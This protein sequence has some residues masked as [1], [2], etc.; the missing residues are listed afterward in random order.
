MTSVAQAVALALPK[1]VLDSVK[2]AE[3]F[4]AFRKKWLSNEE[5]VSVLINYDAHASWLSTELQQRPASGTLLLVNRKVTKYKKDGY[6]WKMRKDSRVTREDNMR[7]KIHSYELVKCL[8]AHSSLVP[9]FHRRSYWLFVNPDVV[10]VHYLND[11]DDPWALRHL[12]SNPFESRPDFWPTSRQWNKTELMNEIVPM[13]INSCTKDAEDDQLNLPDNVSSV[14]E[15]VDKLLDDQSKFVDSPAVSTSPT[16]QKASGY[17]KAASYSNLSFQ[18]ASANSP[19]SNRSKFRPICVGVSSLSGHN[20]VPVVLNVQHIQPLLKV[21]KNETESPNSSGILNVSSSGSIN[22][23]KSPGVSYSVVSS[24]LIEKSPTDVSKRLPSKCEMGTQTVDEIVQESSTFETSSSYQQSA[25][26]YKVSTPSSLFS[27][28]TVAVETPLSQTEPPTVSASDPMQQAHCCFITSEI[29][30]SGTLRAGYF[31]ETANNGCS[32]CVHVNDLSC[33]YSSCLPSTCENNFYHPNQGSGFNESH[34]ISPDVFYHQL[35]T[36][37]NLENPSNLCK[38]ENQTYNRNSALARAF[39]LSSFHSDSFSS[40]GQV[41]SVG[42][43]SSGSCASM[44]MESNSHFQM[45]LQQQ[46]ENLN[47]CSAFSSNYQSDSSAYFPNYDLIGSNQINAS[48]QN[49]Q[50]NSLV[51]TES[52]HTDSASRELFTTMDLPDLSHMDGFTEQITQLASASSAAQ[53]KTLCH[54]GSSDQSGLI[55]GNVDGLVYITEYSPSWCYEEGGE[56][57]LIAGNWSQGNQNDLFQCHFGEKVTQG[58]LILPGVLRCVSPKSICGIVPLSVSRNNTFVT[59]SVPFEYKIKPGT[60]QGCDWF[61]MTSDSSD[62]LALNDHEFRYRL[63]SRLNEMQSH[64]MAFIGNRITH[65]SSSQEDYGNV[66]HPC[67]EAG[68]SFELK[69]ERQFSFILQLLAYLKQ[70]NT[71]HGMTELPR[72]PR[73]L[74]MLHLAAA[75]GMP[76]LIDTMRSCLTQFGGLSDLNPATLDDQHCSALSWACAR[77]NLECALIL[78]NWCHEMLCAKNRLDLTPLMIARMRGHVLLVETLADKET[79]GAPEQLN[80]IHRKYLKRSPDHIRVNASQFTDPTSHDDDQETVSS[81]S[82]YD[83]EEICSLGSAPM[84]SEYTPPQADAM[85]SESFQT[86][87]QWATYGQTQPRVSR[88]RRDDSMNSVPNSPFITTS[89]QVYNLAEQIIRAIPERIKNSRCED[90]PE[91]RAAFDA[92]GNRPR[93]SNDIGTSN[94]TASDLQ[95]FLSEG[96][97]KNSEPRRTDNFRSWNN[98]WNWLDGSDCSSFDLFSDEFDF[99][100]LDH[101]SDQ[102]SDRFRMP[103]S[104]HATHDCDSPMEDLAEFIQGRGNVEAELNSLTLSDSDQR[105]LYESAKIIQSAFR[106]YKVKTKQCRQKRQQEIEAAILIQSYFRKYRQYFSYKRMCRAARLI[107][108]VFRRYKYNNCSIANKKPMSLAKVSNVMGGG[109]AVNSRAGNSRRRSSSCV[110]RLTKHD[111]DQAVLL[112][113]RNYRRRAKRRREND[114]ALKIQR[115]LRQCR[116]K[117]QALRCDSTNPPSVMQY[118]IAQ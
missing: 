76:R 45:S 85:D 19:S 5:V 27:P 101:A 57:V 15:L 109:D 22:P 116:N 11:L 29:P 87:S 16:K 69:F 68:A 107:Q 77:G 13:F 110:S 65:S 55:S 103:N 91:V 7:L 40:R 61:K 21:V 36:M 32:C 48:E 99:S 113:Q 73:G 92:N 6:C 3:T 108:K 100:D 42:T 35:N 111:I 86:S 28:L 71:A 114:A 89:L 1:E 106:Q 12:L 26:V 115:F 97:Q 79:D 41:S 49:V 30:K 112:V 90:S 102:D 24:T 46:G 10:L 33:S 75:L 51:S 8:Y 9:T 104:E 70:T 93:T 94:Q 74:T 2:P 78:H 14:E 31:D 39:D 64:L 88:P 47:Q 118:L 25:N 72:P 23:A 52:E 56:K 66:N 17:Q 98:G 84:M 62:W 59:H 63:L 81:C 83:S 67:F 58:A 117:V 60:K 105:T 37:D 80:S 20:S 50:E 53:H 4:P 43:M 34:D 44:F 96:D 18:S 82:E 95:R 54:N 38:S